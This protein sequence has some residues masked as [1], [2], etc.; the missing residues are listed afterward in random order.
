MPKYLIVAREN[1]PQD[2]TPI[3]IREFAK[4]HDSVEAAVRLV[5]NFCRQKGVGIC[6]V[7]SAIGCADYLMDYSS[8]QLAIVKA[9]DYGSDVR[10]HICEI[11]KA[12][13]GPFWWEV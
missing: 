8:Q 7:P 13:T 1:G 2:K 5:E 9:W 11:G 4:C 12:P 3:P 10:I 6:E